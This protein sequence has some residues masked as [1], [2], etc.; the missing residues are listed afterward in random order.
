MPQKRRSLLDFSVPAASSFAV[1][2]AAAPARRPPSPAAR[3]PRRETA[4][5]ALQP[6]RQPTAQD[7]VAEAEAARPEPRRDQRDAKK[8]ATENSGPPPALE[9]VASAAMGVLSEY[10]N[11]FFVQMQNAMTT[12]LGF[13]DTLADAART[14][15][16]TNGAGSAAAAGLD[17]GHDIAPAAGPQELMRDGARRFWQNELKLLDIMEDFALG[18]FSRRR[19][20]TKAALTASQSMCMAPGTAELM[21]EWHGWADGAAG[22]LA[23]D[24][25][26]VQ[27][28]LQGFAALARG[29][30]DKAK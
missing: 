21:H 28:Y 23:A 4:R 19:T 2:P 11:L 5:A 13:A 1:E 7:M 20:G 8:A 17:K 6:R 12:S 25:A 24:R 9:E 27:R 15:A 29:A 18:W 14:A 22:R 3:A 16:G 30:D 26:A 10:R